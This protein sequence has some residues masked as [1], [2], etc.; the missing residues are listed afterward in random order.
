MKKTNQR[1]FYPQKV[2]RQFFCALVACAVCAIPVNAQSGTISLNKSNVSM[3]TIMQEVEGQSDYTF[4]YNDNQIKLDKKVS[5]KAQ[6]ATIEQVLAQMFKNSGYTYKIVNNQ[7]IV[8]KANAVAAVEKQQQ[9][10][11]KKVT[12]CVKDALGE[13]II[14]ASVVEK[15]APTNGT[16]TDFDGNFTLTVSGNEL[17][18]SYIGYLPQVVKVQSGVTSYNVTLKE[19]TKT[20]DE[21]VVIG[22]GTQ[23]KVNLTG[24]VASVST[25]DIKD[26]VQTNVLSAVQGTVPGVTIISRPG[27][28][29]SINFRGRGNLG[30]S[31]PLYVIDAIADATVFS[32]LDPNTIES[33]SF[34]KDAASSA[35]YGSRAAYGV[36]LV[37]TKGG[38]AEKMNVAYSGY[39]G[40]K[41]PTYLPDVLDSWDYATLLNEAKY[42]ANPSGGKNQAYTNEEIGW[43]RDGSNPDYYPNTN[44]ADLVLDKHVLTTQH[45][46]N[47]SG[48]SE[49]VRFFSSVGYV[50]NDNFMPGVTDDR[51]NLNLNLQ[52]DVTKWLTLKTGVKYIR[53]SSDTKNGTPWIANFVLVP[54]IMVAQQSNGEWGSIAGGKD[55]TQTFMNSNPLRTL[56]FDNWS[57]STTENT[58]Y[59]LGFDLKPIENLVISGQLDY[60]RY[61]Y[62][63]KSYS[64]EYPEVVHF[65]TGKEIPGTG[66]SSP[67]SMSMYW[68]SNSNMMTT[69]TAKYDLKLGQHAVNFLVGTS[70]EHYKYERLYSKRTDFV[71]DGLEDI[72]QGNNIS[73][74]LPD[75]RGIVES[76]ML[77]YFGRINYSYKDRYLFEANLR[78][79]AS[80]RFHKDNRWGW[81]PSFSAGWRIS[82][83]SFMKPIAW[84]NNLKLRAS[85]GTLGN[86]N[87]VGYYDYFELLSSNANYNFNDEP[88]K[89][90]LEAQITNK[91]L[92]WETVALADF[93]LDVDLFDN[94]LSVTA[95]YYIKNTKDILLGY[96]V[97]A[98]TGIWTKPVMNLAKVRNTGFEL[99]AT[100]RNKIG[101]LSY[102]VSGNIATNNNEIVTLAGSDNMI[103]NG[104]DVVRYILKE[105]EAIGSYYGLETDGLYTQEEIDAG[106]YYKYG[107]KPN[108]GDIKYVPQRENVEWGDDI[109]DDDRTIIGKD[110]PD[111][112]YGINI[113][114]QWKNFELSAFGQGVSG[115][116]VAFESEQVFAFMLNSNPRKYHL[117][118]WNED[119]PNPNAACPR[120]YGGNYYDEYNKHFS[121]YQ[122]FDADYFRIKT[123]SLGYMV[124]KDAVTRWGLSSLKFF[125]TGE[126]LFTF[127]ADKDMKDFDPE[128]STGRGI[129]AFGAKSVAFGVNVSF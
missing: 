36:V 97:P 56:S 31:A 21:V 55:A 82:E 19:D 79:D 91:T 43:F 7:I 5:V 51:Y 121:D 102:S 87:N 105:G 32:N 33:I 16:I 100:Y 104:G 53:N 27:S 45:S 113:N 35:I 119:N 42:N 107:R 66:N 52:S 106:H 26:R 14:G 44:W 103:Q 49:K 28:T 47:F 59:D 1:L 72:E 125:L 62:K 40:V 114:L 2:K 54:S 34:L 83:E 108:A 12:G 129:S 115:T 9:Q 126:N 90:V 64:A 57:K 73:K 117:S 94:K 60:K 122:L 127:R 17:Q 29:P 110:V 61:E 78:A 37:T 95:D 101:D 88:V 124:P 22:Y 75:G 11:A 23:K 63:S 58:M 89:G 30:T 13:P 8:S 76:K 96:N 10:Q 41:T 3:H 6:N 25:D 69:L 81:F 24:A 85:Y 71:S 4:F 70:Y 68:I 38:K 50:F 20:L 86:I 109:T 77:S 112:T 84:L 48:G 39:V 15:G 46:L 67:N 123:I 18:I 92:G 116:S 99:A 118:R 128:S 98:E 74:D 120:L 65:E 80:S 93:G 111:F